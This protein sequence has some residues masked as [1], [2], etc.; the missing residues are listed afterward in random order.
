MIQQF[1]QFVKNMYRDLPS[2]MSKIF[3]RPAAIRVSDLSEVNVDA[4]L[5]ETFTI[6]PIHTE[7]KLPD[8]TSITVSGW[9]EVLCVVLGLCSETLCSL[10]IVTFE[11]F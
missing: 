1:L 7:K 2:H 5:K 9:G 4:L 8:G 6:T 3:E 11:R 10:T